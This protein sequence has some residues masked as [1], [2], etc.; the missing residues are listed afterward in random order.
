[1]IY[2][3]KE[4][5]LQT[6]SGPNSIKEY[7]DPQYHLT[8]LVEIPDNLNDF[9][10]YGVRIYAKL[11]SMLPLANVKS[12]PAFNMLDQLNGEDKLGTISHLIENSSGNTVS[13]L[14]II[15]KAFGIPHTATI[16][17]DE[18]S[19][20]KVQLI[21]FFGTEITVNTEPQCPDPND[22]N[23]GIIKAR[24]QGQQPGWLNPG[25][26]DNPDNPESHTLITGPQ[27]WQQLNGEI[28]IFAAGLGTT[29]TMFG[30]ARFLKQKNPN[31]IT[32]G[33]T[34]LPY[35][36][37]SG[38]RTS[39]LLTEIK[40]PWK[41]MVDH[42][43]E[44]GTTDSYAKSLQLAR[45]GLLAGPSSGLALSGLLKYL[46]M[47]HTTNQ[48]DKFRNK[49]GEINAVFICP[50]SP[51]PYID[52]YFKY[53]DESH[54]PPIKNKQLLKDIPSHPIQSD[55]GNLVEMVEPV[56][57]PNNAY[58][59]LYPY[60]VNDLKRMV[61]TDQEIH[62]HEDI[63]IIDVRSS[64]DYELGH[65]PKSIN[66]PHVDFLRNIG[67]IADSFNNQQILTICQWGIKSTLDAEVL[68]SLGIT[69]FG[70]SGGIAKWQ[71]NNLPLV[72]PQI[73]SVKYD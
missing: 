16:I 2:R 65:L 31:I 24:L 21:R 30:S 69:S 42:M 68:R 13:S 62:L 61:S 72:K 22:P 17:S 1:M 33:V 71:E 63:Q 4:H 6:Y 23:A 38:V 18:T 25:Q 46:E 52:D 11:M 48:L 40:F 12:I 35:D 51:L 7:L 47:L 37:V 49:S 67:Q 58:S 14:G 10:C 54:F 56:L 15:G 53:L 55:L 60:S 39:N 59:R 41:S 70:I 32:V 9:R 44:I 45:H 28:D 3:N 64:Q 34:R 20:S 29:G 73:C 5:N 66:I 36:S 43:E 26:Y 50:D 8:P 27:I 19:I 57:L